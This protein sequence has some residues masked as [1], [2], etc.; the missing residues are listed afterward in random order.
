MKILI[1]S[2]PRTGGNVFSK[3]LSVELNYKWIHEPFHNH[4]NEFNDIEKV[5]NEDNI[6]VK[7]QINDWSKK[8][9][10]TKF[11]N[12][13]DK[14]IGLTRN[15]LKETSISLLK[16]FETKN[17]TKNYKIDDEW[18]TENENKLNELMVDIEKDFNK[19]KNISDSLQIT[20]EGIY[21]TKND[22][23]KIMKYIHL[24]E[25]KYY[26]LI[27]PKNRYRNNIKKLI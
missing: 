13:F 7:V 24:N 19:I 2:S 12:F 17:F 8:Y 4:F 6:V 26:D 22:I 3:W 5:L 16:A 27:N 10:D 14:I 20:Y 11:Y 9:T 18:I 23:E 21:E 25:M 1:I 15:N